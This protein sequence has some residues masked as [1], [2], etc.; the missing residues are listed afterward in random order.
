MTKTQTVEK[1]IYKRGSYSYQV[2]LMVDGHSIS[3]TFDT[4]DEARA[5][6]NSKRASLSLDPDASR[7]LKARAHRADV[8]AATLDKMLDKYKEEVSAKKKSAAKEAHTIAKMR[9]SALGKKSLYR[10]TPEDVQA[11]LAGLRREQEGPLQGKPSSDNTKRRHAALLSHLF[12]IARK[13]WRMAVEN[14][15]KEIEL[16]PPGKPRKRRLEG[17]EEE[18]L[19]ASLAKSRKARYAIPLAQIA[20]A[21]GMRQGELL[22]LEWKDVKIAGDIGTITLHD[23]TTKNNEGRVVPLT[24]EACAVLNGMVRPIKGGRVFPLD[25]NSL[26]TLWDFAKKRAKISGLRFHDL[27]HE[28][29]SRLFELGLDRIEA[30]S[31]TG[32]KTLQVLKDYTHLRAEKLAEKLNKAAG[33]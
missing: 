23:G 8:K 10:I 27:R 9:R 5:Y 32:H 1:G 15:V 3:G 33:K 16:P 2:K 22:N 29:T 19:F 13:R 28:A 12:T 30:A 7:V 18:R 25:E 6:L 20:V 31:I 11:Y 17:D 21:T 4:I 24:A 26:R 14:P